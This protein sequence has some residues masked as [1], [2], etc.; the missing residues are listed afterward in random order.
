MENNEEKIRVRKDEFIFYQGAHD[1]CNANYRQEVDMIFPFDAEFGSFGYS[2]VYQLNSNN[3]MEKLDI[4]TKFIFAEIKEIMQKMP[5][6]E[7][8]LNI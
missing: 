3:K 7:L 6:I 4:K 5:R 2:S 8:I 1:I